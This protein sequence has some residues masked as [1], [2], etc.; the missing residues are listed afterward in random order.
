MFSI[1]RP[2][3]EAT[4]TPLKV[5]AQHSSRPWL[6][7][8]IISPHMCV[9]VRTV[10]PFLWRL[11]LISTENGAHLFRGSD[12]RRMYGLYIFF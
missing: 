5:S 8:H 10:H 2:S 6:H 12:T 3:H 9:F 7:L 1:S 11:E 4:T